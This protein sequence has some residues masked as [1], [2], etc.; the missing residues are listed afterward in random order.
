MGESGLSFFGVS[1]EDEKVYRHVLRRPRSTLPELCHTLDLEPAEALPRL[2]RLRSL[3]LVRLAAGGR[4]APAHPETALA[5][6][7]RADSAGRSPDRNSDR[8]AR[9]VREL[10]ASLRA[11]AAA[12]EPGAAAER[13]GVE[14][15]NDAAEIRDRVVDWAFQACEE[16]LSLTPWHAMPPAHLAFIRPIALRC[17]RR[18]LRCRVIVPAACL[19]HPPT[20]DYLA[21][22]A[23]HGA[24][25][26][27][28]AEATER[29]LMADRRI[30][31]LPARGDDLDQGALVVTEPG[32]LAGLTGLFERAWAAAS[33]YPGPAGLADTERRVLVAM[34][35][36]SLDETGARTVGV[37]VRTYRRRVAEL[38]RL[39]GAGNRAQAALLARDRGWI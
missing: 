7:S 21:E 22:L 9:D 4:I 17:L 19:E 32:I 24:R 38:M 30:A 13:P 16:V 18:G 11:E 33:P 25:I 6:L 23:R 29:L 15:V 12:G 3:G 2:R 36:G 1:G 35:S 27:L 5:R 8:F 34:C 28:V 26:R 10:L 39:L 14:L 37:S 31:L 20:A